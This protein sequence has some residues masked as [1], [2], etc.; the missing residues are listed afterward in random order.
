MNLYLNYQEKI[1]NYLKILENKNIIKIPNTLKN[2][3]VELPPKSQKAHL[4]C[5]AAMI[6]AKINEIQPIELANKLVI[7]IKKEDSS[8]A[9]IKV[10][11]PGFINI[12]FKQNF[13][14]EFLKDIINSRK[15]YG[16]IKTIV[17]R[18]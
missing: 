7:L 10:A 15:T 13:W 6:L 18:C 14:N 2:I 17:P 5:N 9:N 16:S 1:F 11:K 12:K 4:S 8:I 3:T